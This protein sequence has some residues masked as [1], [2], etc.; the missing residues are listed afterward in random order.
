MIVDGCLI[1][2]TAAEIFKLDHYQKYREFY[3]SLDILLMAW[4]KVAPT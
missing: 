2:I 4:L 1:K 3:H